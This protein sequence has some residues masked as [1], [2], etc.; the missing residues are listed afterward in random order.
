MPRTGPGRWST[1]SARTIRVSPSPGYHQALRL[2]RVHLA[3]DD[4]I[5]VRV[6]GRTPP[7]GRPHAWFD[8]RVDL[9]H[10]MSL[11]RRRRIADARHALRRAL[12]VLDD[13]GAQGWADR[14]RS[15]LAA[16]GAPVETAPEQVWRVLSPQE[17]QIARLAS[18]GLTNREIGSRLYLSHR[19]VGSHLYRIFPKLGITSRRELT[20]VLRREPESL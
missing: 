4:E 1:R 12:V 19:T 3:D 15:E 13:L 5:D 7:R 18:E 6:Q 9:A 11:R 2:A 8:A 20:G 16:T 14:T 10:G 17:L